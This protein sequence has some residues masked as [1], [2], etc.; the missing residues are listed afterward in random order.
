MP[1]RKKPAP[2]GPFFFFMLEFRRREETKGKSFPGGM[3]QV[4]QEA[5]PSWNRLKEA[6]RQVY[7]DQAAAYKNQPKQNYGEKYTAQGVPYSLVEM[8]KQEL[9]KKQQT[10]GLVISEMI[11][12]A[13]HNNVLEKMQMYFISINHFCKTSTNVFVPAELAMVQYNL[14]LGVQAK[15]HELINPVKLP[16]G[17]ALEATQLSEETHE[18]PIPPNAMGETDLDNVLQKILNFTDY[19]NNTQKQFPVITDEKQVPVVESILEQC[20]EDSKI[21]YRFLVIPLGEFFFH[22]KRATEKYG[23]DICTFPSKTIADILLKKDTYEYTSGIACDFHEKRGN[24]RFCAL[25]K[26]VRWTYILS[27][28]CCLDL[29]IDLIAGCHLPSNADTTLCLNLAETTSYTNQGQTD[30]L[31]MVSSVQTNYTLPNIQ[32]HRAMSTFY[33]EKCSFVSRVA[34][35]SKET[36][37]DAGALMNPFQMIDVNDSVY[38]PNLP[39]KSTEQIAATTRSCK[40]QDRDTEVGMIRQPAVTESGRGR[41][42]LLNNSFSAV[43]PPASQR[44]HFFADMSSIG[45]NYSVKLSDDDD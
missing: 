4:M 36:K 25:S 24:T 7:K 44:Q 16:L 18:L 31:S 37:K 15:M 30:G 38:D 39:R 17:L 33:D 11:Q 2:K 41:G 27:D 9:L 28:N 10:I 19:K 43:L 13:M 45:T 21:D 8:Q 3:E 40:T 23:L 5:G 26:A 1:A 22:L 14:E 6:E 12:T 32:K 42:A 20:D 35:P 34:G 29:S